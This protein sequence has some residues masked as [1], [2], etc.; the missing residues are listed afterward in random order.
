MSPT[1][2][3][4]L[5]FSLLFMG[6]GHIVV[7]KQYAKG[8][9]FA[10]CE[11]VFIVF[12]PRTA[13]AL[14]GLVTLGTPKPELPITE[15][16]NSIFMLMDGIMTVA[17]IGIFIAAYFISVKSALNTYKDFK[18]G[19]KLPSSRS[20][21]GDI[22]GKAFPIAALSPTV[23]LVLFFVMVPLLFSACV[24]F[25]N[26]SAPDHTVPNNT[27]DWVGFSNFQSLFGGD[28]LWTGAL[29][30]VV[31]WT[32]IW[33]VL[34]TATCYFGGMLMAV[35][36]NGVNKKISPLFR[37]VMI[38]P[39]AV[40]SVLT[41]LVWSNLLNGAF[42]VVNRTLMSIGLI[43]TAI[44][45]LSDPLLAKFVVVLI[46]LWAGFP[47]FM[48][49]VMGSMTSISPEVYEAARID[50]ASSPQ[51]TRWVTFP[52]VTY[53]TMPLIIM[54]FAHNINNFGA[55][56]FLTGGQPAVADST[57]TAAKGTDIIVSW[58]Y[59]LTINLYK[60]N[61]ASVLAVMV[62][63]VLAPFAIFN[64]MRTKSYKEGD[65]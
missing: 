59:N 55:I 64:F 52:L 42:G 54:S 57:I 22:S 31:L 38:L 47:Y 1:Y 2:K 33:A 53:Q 9:L 46:N 34:A 15:R 4:T 16:D 36:M 29:G 61:Y 44:P 58:I 25:T 43:S 35:V 32:L 14:A 24:A 45:W 5:G 65:V 21:L 48:L 10:L 19:G 27:V 49:L 37:A 40:P 17:I 39:Y 11:I 13:S 6:L 51:V 26:Y 63:V 20:A 12:L 60:Y 62:F 50:G 8:I 23:L 28:A 3:K 56:F 18:R 30:R 41:L 7:L